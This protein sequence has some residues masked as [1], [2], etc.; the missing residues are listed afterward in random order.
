MVHSNRR[1]GRLALLCSAAAFPILALATS[2]SADSLPAPPTSTVQ[3]AAETA[4]DIPG[5]IVIDA[6]DNLSDSEVKTLL[7]EVANVSPTATFTESD[8][9]DE[10]RIELASVPA[11][12]VQSVVSKLANDERIE[13]VEPLA[14]VTANFVPNDPLFEKQWHMERVGAPTAWDYATGVGVTVAVIDTGIACEDFEGFMKGTD[15]SATRCVAGW[16]FIRDNEHANDDHGHGTHVA[17]TIA[18]STNNG[19]GATGLAFD[20][21]LMPIKVLD[22]GGWGTTVDIANGIRWAS[23][24]GAQVINLSLGGPRNSGILEDAIAHARSQ[25]TVVVAAAGNSGGS[26]GYPGG[27]AGVIGVSAT[28]QAD[29]LAAFSSRGK[30]VD[31]AAP[32]VDVVQQTICEN[33]KNK[34]EVFPGW[35]GTS[36]ASP[37]VAAAAALLVGMGVSDPDAVERTLAANARVVDGSENGRR[38]F[39]AGILDAAATVRAVALRQG[40]TRLG[41]V[42]VFTALVAAWARSRSKKASGPN[43]GF[44]LAALAAGPGLLFFA[45]LV[46][47]RT[48]L[49]IDILARPIADVDFYVGASLHRLLPLAHVGVPLGLL[50]LTFHWKALRPW[51]AGIAVGTAAYLASIAIFHEAYS[52]FG[53][54]AMMVWCGINAAASLLVARFAL[55]HAAD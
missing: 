28:D 36:M 15:L 43:L 45:P 53:A 18:Q 4:W 33:G 9:E 48:H 19:I 23:D 12:D 44:V 46:L 21:R 31:I 6:K 14:W 40:L 35:R 41:L 30:G 1:R 52:P 24:H 49:P 29:A 8:L 25:G 20:V 51:V 17:G 26:V 16:N 2:A 22:K 10:T 11:A 27:S 38:Q 54:T 42:A 5:V 37:H 34:C 32:G 7:D 3:P 13:H 55:E 47:S 50:V 39:G